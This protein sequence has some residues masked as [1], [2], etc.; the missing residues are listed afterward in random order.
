MEG[1]MLIDR[2]H[3]QRLLS[4][5]DMDIELAP[6]NVLISEPACTGTRAA[7]HVLGLSRLFR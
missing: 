5:R 2:L 7:A 1:A 6:L 4:F 3:L